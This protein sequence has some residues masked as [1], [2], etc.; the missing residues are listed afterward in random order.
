[1]RDGFI[2]KDGKKLRC[3]YTTGSSAASASKAAALMLFSGARVESVYLL[4]PK[5]VGLTLAVEDIEFGADYVSCAV[6]KDGG[7]DPDV[8]DGILIYAR[9]SRFPAETPQVRIDGGEGIGRVTKPGLDQP[10]GAA[11]INSV[12]REMI[13]RSVLEVMAEYGYTG[14]LSVLIFAPDGA[15]LA[16]RTFNPRLGIVGGI[17][18]LGTT[19]IVEPMSDAA[20]ID[21]IRVEMNVRRAAGRQYL[22]LTPGNYGADFISG[23][24]GLDAESAVKCANFIGDSLEYAAEAGFLGILLVGHIGKL[25]KLAGGMMNTHSRYGDCRAELF[26]AHAALC[27]ADRDT[28]QR[29]MES[30]MTDDMLEIVREAGL[31]GEVIR[32]LAGKI[33]E[34]VAAR[35][36]GKA[37]TGI[38]VF[39]NQSGLLFRSRR[40]QALAEK[41]KAEENPLPSEAAETV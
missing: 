29:L 1:M 19:G 30:V 8:T 17:S 37:E 18:I 27:G 28:V 39:S 22:L 10:P 21:T 20:V 34:H 41:I 9:V 2:T 38:V 23:S 32:S 11:A 13:T 31:E 33:E 16:A 7:D 6:K 24:M 3:G 36:F 5:G 40:V 25:V 14:G 12:P 26:A 15:A 35:V 4:T